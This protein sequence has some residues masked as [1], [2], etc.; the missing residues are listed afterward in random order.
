MEQ[1]VTQLSRE[2]CERALET[3]EQYMYYVYETSQET[4]NANDCY[5]INV[6]RQLINEHFELVEHTTPK[7]V[8]WIY[9]DEPLC[10]SCSEAIDAGDQD[11]CEFCGQRLDW[12]E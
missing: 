5:E 3:L 6:F 8:V 1:T 4:V 12:R 11:L 7:K 2:E 9:N 10:P